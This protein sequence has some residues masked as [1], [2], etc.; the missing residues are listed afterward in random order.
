MSYPEVCECGNRHH[1]MLVQ[2]W[3]PDA[4]QTRW[5]CRACGTDYPVSPNRPQIEPEDDKPAGQGSGG[6]GI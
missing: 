5:R 2:Q 3:G 6:G 4:W 1:W